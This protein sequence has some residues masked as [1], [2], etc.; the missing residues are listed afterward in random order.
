MRTD[1]DFAPMW[2]VPPGRTISDLMKSRGVASARLARLVDMSELELDDL[3]AGQCAL[4]AR[5]AEGLEAALGTPACFW[6][7]REEQYR[8]QLS[9]LCDGVDPDS[10]SY[11]DWLKSLPLKEMQTLGWVD[12]TKDKA[13]KLRSCL[14]FFGVP[15]LDAWY[16]TYVDVKAAAAF[17]TTDAYLEDAPATAAWLRQGELL[18]ERIE[19]QEWNPER[20]AAQLPKIRSLTQLKDPLDFLPK[21]RALCA[22][23][24]VAVVTVKAPKG[25]RASG[26][27]FFASPSKAV[28]LLSF[29]YLTDDQFWFSFFHEAGH[30]ILHWDTD[31]LIL[32][33][34]DGPK[35]PREEEANQFAMDQL[36]SRELQK[37]LP[38]ASKTLIGIMRLA[39]DA[40]VSYG[41]VLGQMQFRGLVRPD[42][43]NRLKTRYKWEQLTS[44]C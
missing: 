44:E 28:L 19:C 27:T 7:R 39:R 38:A 35:S 24:G 9:D 31:L 1:V 6:L 4:T 34:S 15:N 42:R 11:K 37:R 22:V 43:F 13:E 23:A 8:K 21:L 16:R 40:G 32:E 36:M 33:T 17:R 18:A 41:I 10:E 3:L 2:A 29:R 30:L 5:V 25:C 20:F 14:E 12:S 26:A